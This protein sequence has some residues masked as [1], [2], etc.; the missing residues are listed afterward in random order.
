MSSVLSRAREQ[1]MRGAGAGEWLDNDTLIQNQLVFYIIDVRD[2][3]G[4]GFNGN[5]RWVIR[6]EPFYD[7]EEDPDGLISLTDNP[8]RR[9]FMD[10]LDQELSKLVEQNEEPVIGPCVMVRLKGKNYR[11]IEIVD[12][13]EQNKRPILPQGAVPAGARVEEEMRPRR[14]RANGQPRVDD[15]PGSATQPEPE[16]EQEQRPFAE[17]VE[18]KAE[19]SPAQPP[20]PTAQSTT[21][22][23]SDRSASAAESP[24]SAPSS[25]SRKTRRA[26]AT[27]EQSTLSTSS[28]PVTTA[29]IGEF[30]P[31]KVWAKAN[32]FEV[33]EGR[34]R[35][36]REVKEAY[37]AAK[38]AY[39]AGQD[40]ASPVPPMQPYVGDAREVEEELARNAASR[41]RTS[42]K[43][44]QEIVF[45]PGMPGTSIQ[46]CPACGKHIHDRI[47][48]LGEPGSGKFALVHAGCEAGGEQAMMEAVPD[49]SQE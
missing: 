17:A 6:V 32:N 28:R 13:D 33:P 34:G 21:D 37:E 45:R 35:V 15:H 25:A 48:P 12:W 43:G 39:E 26:A 41:T 7:N 36:K 18:A 46:P 14:P 10:V 31:I 27:T 30:P 16:Q 49:L 47:F 29:S 2:D 5:D 44:V 42:D 38:A 20:F 4:G 22:N 8:A 1:A 24:E 11:Y 3:R 40:P 23:A 9:K 19:A